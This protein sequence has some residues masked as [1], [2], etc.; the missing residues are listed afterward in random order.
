MTKPLAL[1]PTVGV[2]KLNSEKSDFALGPE[3]KSSVMRI[4]QWEDGLRIVDDT[5]DAHDNKLHLESAYRFDGLDYGV[6]GSPIVDT[7]SARR[8]TEWKTETAWRK[9][10]NVM[11]TARAIA[12]L[13]GRTLRVI[14]TGLGVLGRI[15]DEYLVYERQ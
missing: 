3:P 2:W 13:D 12:S 9:Q 15:A 14:R 6:E 5:V 8:I 1:N 10:G 11:I 4:E 7:V